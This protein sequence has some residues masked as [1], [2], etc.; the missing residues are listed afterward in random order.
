[1]G[2][3]TVVTDSTS[4]LP[5]EMIERHGI[6]VVPLYVVFDGDRPVPEV[7]ITDYAAF[8]EELRTADKLP[9]TSQP[10]VG[11]FTKAFEPLLEDGGEVASIHI[12]GGLSGTPEAARQ[13]KGALERDG[14]G[15]ER[16]EVV[17][18]RTAAGGLGMMVLV[19]AKAAAEGAGMREVVARVLEAR[20]ELKIWFA[21]DTLEFLRR[22]GRIGAASAWIGSTLK[23]KPIL[24][25]ENEMTPV[26]RVRTS[27]RAFERMVDYARQ[28]RDSGADAW[29]VQHIAAPE[30]CARLVERCTEVFGCPPTLVSELG[31][32]LAAHTGPGLLGVGGLPSRFVT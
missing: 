10:S 9:T 14:R 5:A 7:E 26:E 18:S 30:Q 25:V 23:V 19:A 20:K 1:M 32:V 16:I 3:V 24:T 2:P 29:S 15:G 21:I 17:D 12:S 22:G 13:A 31:P 11:D 8:F 28:R 27:G 6:R 4:Y